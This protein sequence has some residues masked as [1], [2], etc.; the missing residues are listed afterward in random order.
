[1]E[2]ENPE[3]QVKVPNA[4]INACMVKKKKALI[5]IESFMVMGNKKP[6]KYI[7]EFCWDCKLKSRDSFL[8]ILEFITPKAMDLRM[9]V[10]KNLLQGLRK[11]GKLFFNYY[12]HG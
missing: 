12:V 6:P 11:A 5:D 2:I 9:P 10:L 1:M 3:E 7:V 4:L 8:L